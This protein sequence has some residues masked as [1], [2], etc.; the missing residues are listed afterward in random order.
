MSR[1]RLQKKRNWQKVY[2]TTKIQKKNVAQKLALKI[3]I[4][5]FG[6]SIREKHINRNPKN[7]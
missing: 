4:Y 7:Q 2:L 3:S 1:Y 6:K 5:N